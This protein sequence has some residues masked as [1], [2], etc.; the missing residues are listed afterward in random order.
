MEL[1][2]ARP[3]RVF[4]GWLDARVHGNTKR[5]ERTADTVMISAVM[6][7]EKKVLWCTWARLCSNNLTNIKWQA[8][9]GSYLYVSLPST[10]VSDPRFSSFYQSPWVTFFYLHH[11]NQQ[12]PWVRTDY[13]VSPLIS[14][15]PSLVF[16][17][18]SKSQFTHC[19]SPSTLFCDYFLINRKAVLKQ[20]ME[21]SVQN[22]GRQ[23]SQ[24]RQGKR[25]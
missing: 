5:R 12:A 24:G 14:P 13:A 25:A 19:W 18:T 7:R 9:T 20:R 8:K 1:A 10:T 3:L 4:S 22:V 23:A 15:G 2:S 6:I 21:K 17:Q 16:R 11:G